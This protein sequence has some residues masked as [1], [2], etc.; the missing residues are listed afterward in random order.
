M[1][2]K[3]AKS[4]RITFKKTVKKA[5]FSPNIIEKKLHNKRI[6]K[7]TVDNGRIFP[8]VENTLKK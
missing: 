1:K 5:Y 7:I 3:N 2:S 6:V 4:I 8:Q